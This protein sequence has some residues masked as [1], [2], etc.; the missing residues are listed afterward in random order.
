VLEEGEKLQK[1]PGFTRAGLEEPRYSGEFFLGLREVL[2]GDEADHDRCRSIGR[3]DLQLR[4]T[5]GPV[6]PS[7]HAEH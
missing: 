7:C 6:T 3:A 2:F 5:H 4:A 1:G